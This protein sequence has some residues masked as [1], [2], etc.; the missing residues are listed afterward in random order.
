MTKK[1]SREQ[2]N[3]VDSFYY[4]I[5]PR[6]THTHTHTQ[7]KDTEKEYLENLT[8]LLYLRVIYTYVSL[9]LRTYTYSRKHHKNKEELGHV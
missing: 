1:K 9:F 7:P 3:G 2:L 4:I 6:N 5:Y 8:F